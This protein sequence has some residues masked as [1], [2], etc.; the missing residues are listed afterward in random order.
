MSRTSF[1][2]QLWVTAASN[3]KEFILNLSKHV[4]TGIEDID[5]M[6]GSNFS[7]MN[8]HSNLNVALLWNLFQVSGLCIL[9]HNFY[10]IFC[11]CIPLTVPGFKFVLA[12]VILLQVVQWLWLA[13]SEGPHPHLRMETDPVME[14]LCSLIF[15]IPD[16]G[17]RPICT[18]LRTL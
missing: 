3:S 13:L 18:I 4:L 14:M 9:Y 10:C 11:C 7:V 1:L 16:D 6:K 2:H 15:R 12:V 17:H 5:L 8:P